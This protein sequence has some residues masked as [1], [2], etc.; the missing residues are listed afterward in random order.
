[1]ISRYSTVL[2]LTLF[3][4]SCGG[5]KSGEKSKKL[6]V[7]GHKKIENIE[8]DGEIKADTT[9]H[10]VPDFEFVDQD[11]SIITEGTFADKI[12]VSDFFFTTCPTIC[13]TMKAQMLR[14]YEKYIDN[15]EVGFLSH[16]IDPKH[17]S[18][19][20]LH[21]FAEK[22]GIESSKWHFVT[23]DKDEI[24]EQG[25]KGY[26]VTAGE[27]DSAPGGFIHSGAFILVDKDRRIRGI[28]D[29]TVEAD[30]NQLMD[31]MQLLL[32]EYR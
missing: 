29:G 21:D 3:I 13:P 22:L 6:P 31:D 15:D 28:Y 9:Y 11:G 24:Y 12:Y 27:D 1:M 14:V 19:A 26:M 23:G 16:T 30:V 8:V 2:F 5:E 17:D 32:S 25:M 7:L 20:V 10:T 18:V 4:F